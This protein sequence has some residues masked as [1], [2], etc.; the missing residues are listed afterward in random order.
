MDDIA[1]G[2]PHA[3]ET[4][5]MPTLRVRGSDLATTWT[6]VLA[7]MRAAALSRV[8]QHEDAQ[9]GQGLAEYALILAFIAIVAIAALAFFGVQ[10]SSVLTDP[11]GRELS[12]VVSIIQTP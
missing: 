11:V 4:D 5:S 12:G 3:S 8:T 9:R 10:I 6:E 1:V 7:A 2:S